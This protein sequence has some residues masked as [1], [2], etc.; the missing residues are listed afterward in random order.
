LT[1]DVSGFQKLTENLPIETVKTAPIKTQSMFADLD[2]YLRLQDLPILGTDPTGKRITAISF[3]QTHAVVLLS[4]GEVLAIGDNSNSQLG[5]GTPDRAPTLTLVQASEPVIDIAA[6]SDFSLLLTS[7]HSLLGCGL[8]RGAHRPT[9][10]PG[11]ALTKI[12]AFRRTVAAI[13]ADNRVILWPDFHDQ[14]KSETH[15]LVTTPKTLACGNGFTAVLLT[16]GLL[17]SINEKGIS[18]KYVASHVADGGERF[19]AVS[20]SDS[21]I[22]AIDRSK[23]AWVFGVIDGFAKMAGRTMPLFEDVTFVFAAQN[24]VCAI[25]SGFEGIAVGRLPS[26]D[27]LSKPTHLSF[28]QLALEALAGNNEEIVGIPL[29]YTHELLME[30]VEAYLPE[31]L[32]AEMPIATRSC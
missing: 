30:Q 3:S 13:T 2:P 22:V 23:R 27:V 7:N 1:T 21:Y 32:I 18:L 8:E 14:S 5:I 29:F 17:A 12:A 26:G 25:T 15:T 16:N 24:Y 6:G 9:A 19:I 11:L 4:S 10:I 20:A 31:R 28:G